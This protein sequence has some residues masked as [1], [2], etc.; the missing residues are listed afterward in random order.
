MDQRRERLLALAQA[1]GVAILGAALLGLCRLALT[2][3]AHV[4]IAKN[5][6]GRGDHDVLDHA[7]QQVIGG[8]SVVVPTALT[9]L[10]AKWMGLVAPTPPLTGGKAL[11]DWAAGFLGPTFP[12]LALL[13]LALALRM[14]LPISSPPWDSLTNLGFLSLAIAILIVS[15]ACE[16]LVFRGA[17]L[18]RLAESVGA[19]A[20]IL[21][22]SLLFA[23][24]HM[25][26]R[27]DWLAV[28]FLLGVGFAWAALRTGTLAFPIG[29]HCGINFLKFLMHDPFPGASSVIV[30]GGAAAGEISA[31]PAPISRSVLYMVLMIA[32]AE[33][34][35]WASRRRAPRL[36]VSPS[37][38]EEVLEAKV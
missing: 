18:P 24:A 1:M 14:K 28:R 37:I 12:I 20:A 22:S 15:A 17:I 7:L 5:L 32:S 13:G 34:V 36:A 21:L 3:L 2:K 10:I 27:P 16:E 31:Q 29:A 35:R 19:P 6:V 11:K 25:E 4:L 8:V 26:L 9:V 33:V 23:Y 38:V 30:G